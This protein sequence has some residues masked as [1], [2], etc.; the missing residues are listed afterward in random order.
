M[1]RINVHRFLFFFFSPPFPPCF[2]FSVAA[3]SLSL[4]ESNRAQLS[5]PLSATTTEEEGRKEGRKK[6]FARRSRITN[7]RSEERIEIDPVPR[8]AEASIVGYLSWPI[9]INL[10]ARRTRC[11]HRATE[12]R[13]KSVDRRSIHPFFYATRCVPSR[14][15]VVA[16][17]PRRGR[18]FLFLFLFFFFF[19][20]PCVLRS[21]SDT[22]VYRYVVTS[23]R[24]RKRV[25][26]FF[27]VE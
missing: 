17:G 24:A 21:A 9:F 2:S 12:R 18:V 13:E 3:F 11:G 23:S 25:F 6:Y 5:R 20:D 1:L 27:F 19:L 8:S 10:H 14:C 7:S 26:E 16:R 22:R 15:Y 4:L